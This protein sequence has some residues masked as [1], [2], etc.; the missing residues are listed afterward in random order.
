MVPVRDPGMRHGY[1]NKGRP[2][3]GHKAAVV[4]DC[5]FS[6][7]H[8]ARCLQNGSGNRRRV[9]VG[10]APPTVEHSASLA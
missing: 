7:K 3:G 10:H 1:R 8:A 2:F 5:H 6:G 9:N 4:V